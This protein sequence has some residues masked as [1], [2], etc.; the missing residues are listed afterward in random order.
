MINDSIFESYNSQKSHHNSDISHS[1]IEAAKLPKSCGG[2]DAGQ[3][4]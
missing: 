2:Y 4:V 3:F 1:Q